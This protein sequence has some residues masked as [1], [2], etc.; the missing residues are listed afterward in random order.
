MISDKQ[1]VKFIKILKIDYDVIGSV[2][3]RNSDEIFIRPIE[4]PQDIEWSGKIPFYSFKKYFLKPAE[5][6]FEYNGAKL[7]EIVIQNER[8]IALFGLNILDLRAIG[9]CDLVFKRD[10]Y[11]QKKRLKNLL[12]GASNVVLGKREYQIFTENFEEN[13]LEHL[14]FDLFFEKQN[15]NNYRVF[16]GSRTGQKILDICGIKDFEHVQFAGQIREEG[17]DA[18]MLQLREKVRNSANNPV[19]N[20]LGERCYACGKCSIVCP[21]CYCFDLY[22]IKEMNGGRKIREWGSCFYPEFS[23]IA[24]GRKFFDTISKRIFY[25]YYHKF[26]AIP[27]KYSVPGCVSCLRCAKVCPAGID[28]RKVLESL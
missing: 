2:K 22:D 1:F 5:E 21:T 6:L 28:I 19:W 20:E 12:V 26:V 16:T 7:N 11:Y 17:K 24:G 13:I 27:E 9:V 18:R 3:D 15:Q 23:E 8:P 4:S 10:P 25:W 14:H